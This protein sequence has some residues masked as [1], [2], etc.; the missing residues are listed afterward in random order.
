VLNGIVFSHSSDQ[1]GGF[2]NVSQSSHVR[3]KVEPLKY[4]ADVPSLLLDFSR[5]HLI[6]FETVFPVPDEF[7][8]N[9]DSSTINR[10]EMIDTPKKS[11]L[12]RTGGA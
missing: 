12:P 4:H 3:K 7:T 1:Q 10:L 2:N 5:A 6:N 11:R 8:V 9:D